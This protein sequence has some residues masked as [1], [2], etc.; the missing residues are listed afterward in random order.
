MKALSKSIFVTLL[1]IIIILSVIPLSVY[2]ATLT[3][4]GGSLDLCWELYSD[5]TLIL[6]GQGSLDSYDLGRFRQPWQGKYIRKLIIKEGVT[7]IGDCAFKNCKDLISVS[8]PDSLLSIG[9]NAF[10]NTAIYNNPDNWENGA[11][12]I[13]NCLIEAKN[14]YGKFIVK[15]GTELIAASAFGNGLYDEGDMLNEY[16]TS[17]VIPDGVRGIGYAAFGN[18]KKLTTIELPQSIIFLGDCA[19]NNCITLTDIQIPDRITDIGNYTFSG[20]T[21]LKNVTLPQNLTRIGNYAFHMCSGISELTIPNTVNTID[22]LAFYG[23]TGLTK[24]N[25]PKNIE[26]IYYGTFYDCT[27]LKSVS[28]PENLKNIEESAF[29]NCVNLKEINLPKSITLIDAFAF[30]NC[31]RLDNISLPDTIEKIGEGAFYD[32]AHYNNPDNWQSGLL[33]INNCL[34]RADKGI[35]GKYQVNNGTTLIA[36]G[37]FSGCTK[38]T[39][40]SLPAS[41]IN[42]GTAAF[43][44]CT[45]LSSINLPE[46]ITHISDKMFCNCTSLSGFTFGKNIR[47]IGEGAFSGCTGFTS[48]TIPSTITKIKSAAFGSCT[49][50][51]R[52]AL[53]E[54]P[55]FLGGSAFAE[56]AY[57]NNTSNWKSNALYIGKH[58]IRL[59]R[60]TGD[61][62]VKPGTLSVASDAFHKC[63]LDTLTIPDG[64]LILGE[65]LFCTEGSHVKKIIIADSV[66]EIGDSAFFGLYN[67][68]INL[69]KSLKSLSVNIFGWTNLDKLIIP[70]GIT[71]IPS[72]FSETGTNS[73]TIPVSVTKITDNAFANAYLKD[74]YYEGDIVQWNKIDFG[75]G[76][77]VLK[78]ANIHFAKTHSHSYTSAIE[79]RASCTEDGIEKLICEC[80]EAYTK[81]IK[82]TGH[83]WG[84]WKVNLLDT[85]KEVRT[86]NICRF[87][88][89]R[90]AKDFASEELTILG[91]STLK[92]FQ[93]YVFTVSDS[94]ADVIYK[95]ATAGIIICNKEEHEIRSNELLCSGMT[96]SLKKDNLGV[97]EKTVI[98]LGDIDGNGKV[99]AADARLVLRQSVGL[100]VFNSWQ[101]AGANVTDI[102]EEKITASDARYILRASVG[103]ERFENCIS[104]IN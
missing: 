77:G 63:I 22:S 34:I 100:E 102:S 23:C 9:C 89:T 82:A 91:N 6:S 57:Y 47:S 98:I 101:T 81:T 56:T 27:C 86:C 61:F 99:S 93:D 5:G 28:L 66:S 37:A 16:L 78:Y 4:R 84:N 83:E 52:I 35:T 26:S 75:K 69:P 31:S 49:N 58:L 38:V 97:I 12:Y 103:L 40:I 21:A 19:F 87:S 60:H 24:I 25:I 79:K 32:T 30:R 43:S 65:D 45:S 1:S 73:L 39:S 15:S 13:D 104:A 62:T 67:T 90:N 88:E 48:I 76:N 33:Y 71:T 70:E 41:A 2:G 17:I 53:P 18:C 14:I 94:S 42:I 10:Y 50:L 44:D 95:N 54:T 36:D 51:Y 85:E 74:V 8:L 20:C 68:D 64:V 72:I 3:E 96:I 7:S 55:L 59:E 11:L 80:G 46:K 29:Q 92:L